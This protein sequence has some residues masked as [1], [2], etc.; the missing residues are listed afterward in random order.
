MELIGPLSV[1]CPEVVIFNAYSYGFNPD[2]R[3]YAQTIEDLTP[4]RLD[5]QMSKKDVQRL[6][7]FIIHW[8][9]YSN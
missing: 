2:L 1:L 3:A 9:N 4:N 7:D 6:E 8:I 5:F